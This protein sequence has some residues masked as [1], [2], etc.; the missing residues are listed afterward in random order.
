MALHNMGKAGSNITYRC[1]CLRFRAPVCYPA[2]RYHASYQGYV[3][4]RPHLHFAII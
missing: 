1:L 4:A 2:A 3:F